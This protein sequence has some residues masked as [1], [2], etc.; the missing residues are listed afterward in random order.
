[1]ELD[2]RERKEEFEEFEVASSG[3]GICGINRMN[4]CE[5]SEQTFQILT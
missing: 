5:L 2:Q 4:P 3:H 1:M